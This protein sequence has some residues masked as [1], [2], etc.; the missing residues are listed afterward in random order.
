[1]LLLRAASTTV[2]VLFESAVVAA[3]TRAVAKGSE[4]LALDHYLEVFR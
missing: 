1:M 4:V 2:Q 3:H